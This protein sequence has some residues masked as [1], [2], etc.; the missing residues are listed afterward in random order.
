TREEISIREQELVE[1]LREVGSEKSGWATLHNL[2]IVSVDEVQSMLRPDEILV[3]FYTVADRVQAFVITREQFEVV[4][5]LTTTGA[6]RE[7]LKGLTFQL[8]KF[9]LQ[10]A[11][12]QSHAPML[13]AATQ[14]HLRELYRRLIE[15]IQQKISGRSLIVVP[16]QVLHYIPFQALFDGEQY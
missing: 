5:D 13:L 15:P 10:P 6:V 16:H 11:Y 2:K 9:H 3:E 8:S 1:L 12:V 7:S 4:R 14:H